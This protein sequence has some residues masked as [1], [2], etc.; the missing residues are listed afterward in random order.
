MFFTRRKV[1]ES[2]IFVGLC[3][4][5]TH[6]LPAIDD[7]IRTND[8]ALKALAYYEELGVST[9]V[10][11]PHIME[12]YPDNS[13]AML[14]A[15]F[16][17]FKREYKGNITLSLGAEYMLDS[18]FYSHLESG[19]LLPIFEDHLL[20][21]M[22]YVAAS[23]NLEQTVESVISKG[24]FV[25]LAHPERYLYLTK[26]EYKRLKDMGVLFQLNLPSLLGGYGSA[27]RERSEWLIK[28]GLYDFIGSDIHSQS[29][30]S[31]IYTRSKLSRK[32]ISSIHDI[33]NR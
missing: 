18:S 7:G 22:S 3:D 16:E 9:V 12:V 25:I 28:N 21:E 1:I 31:G 26:P 24:Y 2:G 4:C 32:I 20:V 14:R 8:E 13:A 30:I 33:K 6:I 17:E 27:V 11:T 19:D 15:K 5:H 10:L 23:M 29:Y